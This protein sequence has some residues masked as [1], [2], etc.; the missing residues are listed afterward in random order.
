MANKGFSIEVTSRYDGWW[1][2]NV[3]LMAGCFDAADRRTGFASTSSHVAE[4]GSR[5]REAPA[6]I[7][8]DRKAVLT[9][10]PCDHLLLYVYI[11]PHTLPE[12]DDIDATRPFEI[13]MTISCDGRKVDKIRRE[14]N[15]WSGASIEMRVDRKQAAKKRPTAKRNGGGK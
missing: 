6:G 10:E 2:Y 13:E 7:A 9:T 3:A 8:P 15:Q 1:R 11:I 5:L 4:T 12:T 14:I